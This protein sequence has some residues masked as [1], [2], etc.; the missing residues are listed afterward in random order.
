M[1]LN[2]KLITHLFLATAFFTSS[3]MCC[4]FVKPALAA[5]PETDVPACH[6]VV[7]THDAS[8]QSAQSSQDTKECDC[9][10][11]QAVLKEATVLNDASAKLTLFKFHQSIIQPVIVVLNTYSYQPQFTIHDTSPPLYLKHSVLRI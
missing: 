7:Q 3:L 5:V 10:K 8:A 2:V 6:K 9:G 11:P 1:K 4:C